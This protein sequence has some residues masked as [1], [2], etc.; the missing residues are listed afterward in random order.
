MARGNPPGD[1]RAAG[2]GR[3]IPRAAGFKAFHDGRWLSRIANWCPPHQKR[4]P[5]SPVLAKLG[6]AGRL[7]RQKGVTAEERS[8]TLE[9]DEACAVSPQGG[10]THSQYRSPTD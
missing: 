2:L 3:N 6:L 8:L 7:D 1:Q 10:P 9:I 4:R 5:A